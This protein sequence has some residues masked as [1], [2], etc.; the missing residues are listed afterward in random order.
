MLVARLQKVAV[1]SLGKV[2]FHSGFFTDPP[3]IP[4]ILPY[5]SKLLSCFLKMLCPPTV[6]GN[7]LNIAVVRLHQRQPKL[8]SM[9]L[10]LQQQETSCRN[11]G[12]YYT[13]CLNYLKH[14]W[15]LD[16]FT[17]PHLSS[18]ETFE[19]QPPG[20]QPEPFQLLPEAFSS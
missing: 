7:L 11:A 6:V 10:L 1:S 3:P 15:S 16:N 2:L 8:S 20:L 13:M 14:I 17:H 9:A 4:T 19:N 18:L 12:Q 5:K